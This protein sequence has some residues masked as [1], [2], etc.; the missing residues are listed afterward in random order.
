M[1]SKAVIFSCFGTFFITHDLNLLQ[2]ADQ[3]AV[4]N[5]GAVE[6]FGNFEKGIIESQSLKDLNQKEKEI[7]KNYGK[8]LRNSLL[9]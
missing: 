7:G 4:F 6:Y 5:E 1:K 9:V 2:H 8:I 3:I